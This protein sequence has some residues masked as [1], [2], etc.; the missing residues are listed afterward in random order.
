MCVLRH[1]GKPFLLLTSSMARWLLRSCISFLLQ[2]LHFL[3][4]LGTAAVAAVRAVGAAAIA[5]AATAIVA[6]FAT[7][8]ATADVVARCDHRLKFSDAAP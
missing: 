1:M 4:I 3:H 5:A 2:D 8:T 7:A 6:A